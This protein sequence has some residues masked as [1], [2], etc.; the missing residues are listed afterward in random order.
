[1]SERHWIAAV[2]EETYVSERLYANDVVDLPHPGGRLPS[3]GDP[4]ALVALADDPVLFGL[5]RAQAQGYRI[6]YTHRL[7]DEPRRIRTEAVDA[8]VVAGLT[9]GLT[10]ISPAAYDRLASLVAAQPGPRRSEWFVT[11]AL[12]I[13]APTPA[14]AVREFWSYVDKLG[15]RELP[16]L[17]WPR[18]DELAMQAFV[19]GEVA[20]QDPEEDD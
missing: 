11:V 15:P 4:V 3:P 9:A 17:V 19:L 2:P 18:G 5:G 13:E 12:P 10:Q 6:G 7:L 16:A 8:D 20:N 1:M 14:E